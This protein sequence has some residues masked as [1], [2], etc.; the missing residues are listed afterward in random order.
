MT[1]DELNL[2]PE[3][4]L[5]LSNYLRGGL[6]SYGSTSTKT[7]HNI[8]KFLQDVVTAKDTTK[9][10]YL[11]ETELGTPKYPLRTLKELNLF[12]NEVANMKDFA[13][14]FL[15]QG[16]IM[17]STSLSKDAKLLD[18]SVVTRRELGDITHRPKKKKK[19]SGWF[20][21]KTDEEAE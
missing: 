14:Y 21:K 13:D 16:E 8:H 18:L 11:G 19:P 4:E 7:D 20:K 3:E 2:T 6:S 15:M 17:T 10:G 1:E 5:E 12:C 9:L